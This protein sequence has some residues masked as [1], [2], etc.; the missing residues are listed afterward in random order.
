MT[1][2]AVISQLS[3]TGPEEQF[4]YKG[5]DKIIFTKQDYKPYENFSILNYTHTCN[6]NVDF[7]KT[8]TFDIPSKGDIIKDMVLYLKLPALTVNSGTYIGWTNSIGHA[9]LDSIE[10]QFNGY[11]IDLQTGLYLELL[12]ELTQQQSNG[13]LIGKYTNPQLLQTNATTETEYFIPLKFWF[14]W[15]SIENGLPICA[16]YHTPIRVIIKLKPF[17]DCIIYDSVIQPNLASIIECSLKIDYIFLSNQERT[18]LLYNPQQY[19]IKQTQIYTDLPVNIGYNKSF[20][21]LNLPSSELLWVYHDTDSI[22]NNDWFNFGQRNLVPN[23]QTL[24]IINNAKLIL[25]GA[26]RIELTGE[27]QLRL[28]TSKK[29]HTRM[30]DSFIYNYSF[31]NKP[32]SYQPNG[33]IQFS[34]FDN[35]ELHF[36]SNLSSCTLDIIAINYNWLTI[37]DGLFK[38]EFQS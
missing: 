37:V 14:C 23:S 24:P 29:N 5:V 20:L 16:M 6:E 15:N 19:L 30:T 17:L 28:L 12:D 18:K 34:R 36:N 38:L 27:K 32:E 11:R 21:T 2:K 26:D 25:D 7:G 9:I 4:L 33:L 13:Q 35:V 22:S 8:I 10:L 3:N 31:A 1:T